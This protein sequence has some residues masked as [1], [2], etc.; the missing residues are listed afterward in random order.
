MEE[1]EAAVSIA[2][3]KG[4]GSFTLTGLH[5]AFDQEQKPANKQ[6]NKLALKAFLVGEDVL[7]SHIA[8]IHSG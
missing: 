3:T 7:H 5:F 6:P 4:S 2:A 1:D 8:T